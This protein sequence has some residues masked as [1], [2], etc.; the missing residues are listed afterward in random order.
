MN[1]LS[2]RLSFYKK[3]WGRSCLKE[4]DKKIIQGSFS[5][6]VSFEKK[7]RACSEGTLKKLK[8]LF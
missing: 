1:L 7:Y 5:K 3:A 4:T 2:T 8:Q 6:A